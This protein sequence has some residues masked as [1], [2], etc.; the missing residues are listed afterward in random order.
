MQRRKQGTHERLLRVKALERHAASDQFRTKLGKRHASDAV[1]EYVKDEPLLPLLPAATDK[2][3]LVRRQQA[4]RA[5]RLHEHQQAGQ[6]DRAHCKHQRGHLREQCRDEAH[7]AATAS[8][9]VRALRCTAAFSIWHRVRQ[10][11]AHEN[12]H[13]GHGHQGELRELEEA[14]EGAQLPGE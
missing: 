10:R 4:R 11:G 14:S 8:V 7:K 5:G 1:A 12:S 2:H 13:D 9:R 3:S 6:S